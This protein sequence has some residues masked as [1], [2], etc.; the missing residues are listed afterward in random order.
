MP[1]SAPALILWEV[2]ALGGAELAANRRQI[3]DS[4]KDYCLL[5]LR[6][7]RLIALLPRGVTPGRAPARKAGLRSPPAGAPFAP[8]EQR[9]RPLGRNQPQ[10][11][12]RLAASRRPPRPA[13]HRFAFAETGA[14][15]ARLRRQPERHRPIQRNG[16]ARLCKP[17]PIRFCFSYARH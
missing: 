1:A 8:P 13:I 9:R 3:G 12:G 14:C 2:V 16:S 15:A 11:Q 17:R 4:S 7:V 5:A 6:R 10:Q